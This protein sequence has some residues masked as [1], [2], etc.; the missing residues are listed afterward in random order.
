[1]TAELN[2]LTELLTIHGAGGHSLPYIGYVV[3]EIQIGSIDGVQ[4]SSFPFLVVPDTLYSETTPVLIGTNILRPFRNELQ[5]FYGERFQQKLDLPVSI[6]VAIHALNV[7]ERHLRRSE[8]VFGVVKMAE[9]VQIPGNKTVLVEGVTR[10]TV[11][12]SSRIAYLQPMKELPDGLD[13][14]PGLVGIE[15]GIRQ[16]SFE[17]HNNSNQA[18]RLQTGRIVCQLQEAKLEDPE[19]IG[20]DQ[21]TF[22]QQF[23][24]DHL[25][26]DQKQIAQ[27]LLSRW[28]HIFSQSSL[29]IGCTGLSKHRIELTDNVPF[30]DR[31]RRIPPALYE[32]VKQHLREMEDIGVIEESNS[33]YSSNIVLI[34]KKDGS[35]RFCID[36]R[37]LNKITVKDAFALPRIDEILEVMRGASWFSTLDLRSGFW[38]MEV[39]EE[40]KNRTAFTVGPLGFWQFKI[41]P[42]G[43]TNSPSSFQRLMQAV[44]GELYLKLAVVFIDDVNVFACSF[45]EQCCHLEKVFQKLESANLKLKASKCNFFHRKLTYVGHTVSEEGIGCSEDHIKAITNYPVPKTVEELRRFLGM[46]G[47]YRKF[48]KEFAKKA[49]PLYLLLGGSRRKKRKKVEEVT[50]FWGQEQQEAFEELIRCLSTPPVLAF[51]DYSKPFLLRTDASKLGLGAVLLQEQNG[52]YAVIA[53]GSRAVRGAEQN[54]STHKLEFLALKWAVTQKNYDYLYGNTFTVSTDHNPLTY[55]LSTAKLDATGHRWLAELSAYNFDVKYTPGKLNL[56]ADALSRISRPDEEEQIISQ[57]LVNNICKTEE[58]EDFGLIESMCLT[59]DVN[60]PME[61]KVQGLALDWQKEQQADRIVGRVRKLVQDGLLPNA[62]DRKKELIPVQKYFREW[63]HLVLKDG[64]LHRK[65]ISNGKSQLQLVLPLKYRERVFHDLH[66][67]IGHMGRDRT[68]SL[69]QDRFFWPG[70]CKFIEQEIKRCDRCIRANSPHLPQTAPLVRIETTH[71]MQLVC[72]DF[73]TVEDG[74]GGIGNI[75]VITD[76]FTKYAQAFPTNNQT[77]HTTAKVLFEKFIVHYGFPE[78]LHSDQGRNFE[79]KVIECLCKLASVR[80]SRTT[81]YHPMGN[82]IVERFNRTLLGMLRTL[83]D[84]EKRRWKHHIP[85]LVHAYNCTK[86]STTGFSPFYL[87]FGRQ[88]RLAVDIILGLS[89]ME[90]TGSNSYTGYIENLRNSLK[91]AYQIASDAVKQISDRHRNLYNVKIRGAALQI[92]DFVLVKNVGIRGK[93]KLV[94]KW[95]KDVYIIVDQ[96]DRNIPVFAVQPTSGEGRKRILHRN[97]LLPLCLPVEEQD[98]PLHENLVQGIDADQSIKNDKEA[99]ERNVPELHMNGEDTIS[100]RREAGKVECGTRKNDGTRKNGE[101]EEFSEENPD[102]EEH[103]EGNESDSLEDVIS[104]GGNVSRDLGNISVSEEG[105]VP[106]QRFNLKIKHRRILPPN[107]PTSRPKRSRQLPAR[108]RDDNFVNMAQL[109]EDTLYQKCKTLLILM[110]EFPEQI[111]FLEWL[112]EKLICR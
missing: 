8:G 21:D 23:Q 15:N 61:P 4:T 69:F 110:K 31:P 33:P 18:V 99:A 59:V 41:M 3:A 56:D 67:D 112:I 74:K 79:S 82:G 42:F 45:Q 78:R 6:Q 72:M 91:K 47:F 87:L 58:V 98:L 32:E 22:L 83:T 77:A 27:D 17:V 36:Y 92:G 43:L 75:L 57:Q 37:R 102:I 76:H 89:T 34:R 25:D 53:Y 60:M 12:I 28:S 26:K 107:P 106:P 24:L 105:I 88:P 86:H 68:I 1:M 48:V 109:V 50:W 94:D 52:K 80:K 65:R 96:E 103:T 63:E 7:Q 84:E 55:V 90:D 85:A 104:E 9:A 100:T 51:P 20:L 111:T 101:F 62:E 64:V 5:D 93:H 10:L 11:P 73:L 44:L 19:I 13:I 35:L 108:F 71:P 2:P 30:K 49:Q 97:L 14:T 81:P 16:I 38:Q 66:S 29:D 46:A 95:E 39:E 40:H 70:M 54:Y